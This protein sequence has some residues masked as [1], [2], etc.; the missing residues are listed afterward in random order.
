MTRDVEKEFIIAIA[1]SGGRKKVSLLM[2]ID[3]TELSRK[4]GGERGWKIKELQRFCEITG[5]E[6]S[7]D[8]NGV[9]SGTGDDSILVIELSRKLTK[10]MEELR[11]I[12]VVME[13]R[14]I[15]LHESSIEEKGE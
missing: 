10:T 7:G 4:L 1:K 6:M 12:K 13:K 14:G 3:Q 8:G 2:E 11:G 5:M 9:P 15:N